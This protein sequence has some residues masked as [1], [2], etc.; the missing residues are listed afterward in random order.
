[1]M[2]SAK[3]TSTWN[4]DTVY[5]FTVHRSILTLFGSW[6]L[7][8]KNVSAKIRWYLTVVAQITS[9][10]PLSYEMYLSCRDVESI[11]D[12]FM[13]NATTFSSLMKL[14]ILRF[15]RE[16][17]VGMIKGAIE[18]WSSIEDPKY[19]KI[20][21]KHAYMGRLICFSLMTFMYMSYFMY[22]TLALALEIINRNET[23]IGI[24][25]QREFPLLTTCTFENI[26]VPLYCIIFVIQIVQGT[27]TCT[28][29]I[30]N[31]ALFFALTMHL[32]GQLE[33]LKIE[34]RMIGKEPNEKGYRSK[35]RLLVRRHYYLIQLAKHLEDSF[36]VINL[37]QLLLCAVLI[38]VEGFQ[39]IVNLKITVDFSTLKHCLV[40]NAVLIQL[41]LY[42]FSG[43]Y[44]KTQSEGVA[45]AIYDCYWYN[46]PPDEVKDLGL[47]MIRAG[48]PL[49]LTAG[50]FF[51]MTLESFKDIL[52]TSASYMSFLRVMVGE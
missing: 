21:K 34:F 49:I 33:I 9:I 52:K 28:G 45:Y 30:I 14:T 51:V 24:R 15:H 6:P 44:L 42:S 37:M 18:D 40:L 10:I 48:I 17:M 19:R 5:A 20:M 1:M 36:N 11:I 50:K 39:L 38:C 22:I 46:L 12:A 7:Q 23:A 27:I 8:M 25:T 32:C 31:D 43:D 26:S 3:M 29:I 4:A 35:L 16:K 2:A 47:V 13:C 41:F